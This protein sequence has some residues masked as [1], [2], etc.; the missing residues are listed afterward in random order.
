MSS[1]VTNTITSWPDQQD[2]DSDANVGL[3][4]ADVGIEPFRQGL[5]KTE[6]KTHATVLSEGK[7]R[8][9]DSDEGQASSSGSG[10]CSRKMRNNDRNR[11]RVAFVKETVQ[12]LREELE[13]QGVLEPVPPAIVAAGGRSLDMVTKNCA[14]I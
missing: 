13:L 14:L 3:G 10:N 12:E 1:D 9:S 7:R 4:D 8:A 5:A 6:S 11:Q 2:V